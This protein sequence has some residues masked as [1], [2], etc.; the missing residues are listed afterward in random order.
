MLIFA[1]LVQIP[2]L[3]IGMLNSTNCVRV[4]FDVCL[5]SD[6]GLLGLHAGETSGFAPLAALFALA[7]RNLQRCRC[8]EQP[9]FEVLCFGG[10]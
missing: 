8:T 1:A 10:V 7:E 4:I 9:G 6:V 5:V 2:A 3:W